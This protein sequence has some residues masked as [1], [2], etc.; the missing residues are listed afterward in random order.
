MLLL[1]SLF[2][3]VDT[4]TTDVGGEDEK[5]E[6][7]VARVRSLHQRLAIVIVSSLHQR[8]VSI[9]KQPSIASDPVDKSSRSSHIELDGRIS[10]SSDIV[11]SLRIG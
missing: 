3:S 2:P 10:V 9:E 5:D 1:H 7:E 6:E 11:G 4:R 8:S